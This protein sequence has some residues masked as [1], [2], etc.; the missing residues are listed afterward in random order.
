LHRPT[1]AACWF[2]TLMPHVCRGVA[3]PVATAP[4]GWGWGIGHILRVVGAGVE[5]ESAPRRCKSLKVY[6]HKAFVKQER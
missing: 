3:P 4:G 2:S 6:T 5:K 1:A